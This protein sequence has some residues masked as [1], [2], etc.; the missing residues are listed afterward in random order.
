MAVEGHINLSSLAVLDFIQSLL[1][2]ISNIHHRM[3]NVNSFLKELFGI[4]QNDCSAGYIF[5]GNEAFAY[6]NI[7]LKQKRIDKA[8][9]LCY[10]ECIK[11]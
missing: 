10:N 9:A 11:S 7:K 1:K 6:Y 2:L 5:S 4:F 3:N 8:S